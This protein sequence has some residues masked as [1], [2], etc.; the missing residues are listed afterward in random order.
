MRAGLRLL[1]HSIGI[2]LQERDRLQVQAV[3]IEVRSLIQVHSDVPTVIDFSTIFFFILLTSTFICTSRGASRGL[4]A[5][6]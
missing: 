5:G 1:L 4:A 2:R 6:N 3:S